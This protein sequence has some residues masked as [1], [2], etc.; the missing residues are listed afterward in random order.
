MP[1]KFI[2]DVATADCAVE[3]K[4]ETLSGIFVDAA[5]SLTARMIDPATVRPEQSWKIELSEEN[6]RSL[7]YAWLS[8][9]VFIRDSENVLLS[10][11]EVSSLKTD[12]ECSLSAVARGE[13]IDH[14]RHDIVVEVK[15]VT[16]HMFNIEKEGNIWKAF[17]VYD[18]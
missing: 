6:L 15:A 11:F 7:L 3:I 13:K 12:G 5:K 9:L 17:V 1:F 16:M 4:A 2:D 10:D 8:E 18:L 14:G